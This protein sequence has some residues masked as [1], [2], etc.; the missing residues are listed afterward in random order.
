MS[1]ITLLTDF[2]GRDTYVGVMH[3]VIHG[4]NPRATVVDLC[5][6]VP[7]Q[8]LRTA[9]FHLAT[10]YRYF[11]A[12]AIHV[13]VVDPGVGSAR[14]PMA[15]RASHGTFVA[16]DNGLLSPVLAREPVEAIV[17][18][19]NPEFWLMPVSATFHGRNV[20]APVAAHLSLGVPM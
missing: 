11:P 13:V 1:I 3:G 18:L 7:P 17:E 10:A 9:A 19:S 14:R 16:P 12:E 20:F 5:H 6:E 15:V 8:D 4:I 2:G